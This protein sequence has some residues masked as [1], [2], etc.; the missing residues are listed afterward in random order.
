MKLMKKVGTI[1]TENCITKEKNEQ[2][3][4]KNMEGKM[5]GEFARDVN[6]KT[7]TEDWWLWMRRS[8]LKTE[9]VALMCAA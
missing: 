6:A 9:T 1:K 3:N 5:Y 8:E 7:H 4:R 2:K